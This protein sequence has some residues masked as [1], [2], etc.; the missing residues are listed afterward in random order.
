MP[1]PRAPRLLSASRRSADLALLR[2]RVERSWAAGEGPDQEVSH[3]R[4]HARR[5]P[6]GSHQRRLAMFRALQHSHKAPAFRTC[7]TAAHARG[8]TLWTAARRAACVRAALHLLHAAC[9]MGGGRAGLS[10]RSPLLCFGWCTFFISFFLDLNSTRST[11]THTHTHTR[12]H[13]SQASQACARGPRRGRPAAGHIHSLSLVGRR[14]QVQD[15]VATHGI[16]SAPLCEHGVEL[17]SLL[18]AGQQREEA[19]AI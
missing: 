13:S 16:K 15:Y 8:W 12:T 4:R 19:G 6:L 7:H 1:A 2:R 10:P 11:H 5:R 9:T 18:L 3:A 14:D 17:G